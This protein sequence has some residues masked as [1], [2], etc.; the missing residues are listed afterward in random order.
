MRVLRNEYCA[1]FPHLEARGHRLSDLLLDLVALQ[2]PGWLVSPRKLVW[3]LSH[4]ENL[5][6]VVIYRANLRRKVVQVLIL[7]KV[8][9]KSLSSVSFAKDTDFEFALRNLPTNDVHYF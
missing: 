5:I 6:I 1:R 7:E 3:S 8:D 4:P 2:A 9:E